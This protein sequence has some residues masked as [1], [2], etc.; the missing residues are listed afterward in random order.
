MIP[1]FLV[2]FK[3]YTEDV[4]SDAV[5]DRLNPELIDL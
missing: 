4:I 5:N 2:P 1:D 3:H